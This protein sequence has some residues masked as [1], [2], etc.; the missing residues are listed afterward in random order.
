M[1][2]PVEPLLVAVIV[3]LP[4]PKVCAPSNPRPPVIVPW[5]SEIAF[6]KVTVPIACAKKPVRPMPFVGTDIVVEREVPDT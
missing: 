6:A 1:I 3:T 5:L 2:N 4:E